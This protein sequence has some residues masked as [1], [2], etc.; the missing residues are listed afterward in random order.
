MLRES[1]QVKN[2]AAVDK[3]LL[4]GLLA[5]PWL[6][7]N[8]GGVVEDMSSQME[9][10][11]GFGM[12]ELKG[13]PFASLFPNC[14]R[15]GELPEAQSILAVAQGE[16]VSSARLR[17]KTGRL[18]NAALFY[19]KLGQS[20][21]SD[22]KDSFNAPLLIVV[23]EM[24]EEVPSG[25]LL[26]NVQ[27]KLEGYAL[28]QEKWLLGLGQQL[29]APLTVMT[30]SLN[31]LRDYGNKMSAQERTEEIRQ[32]EECVENCR[33][34]IEAAHSRIRIKSRPFPKVEVVG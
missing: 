20:K 30:L 18:I 27:K 15:E 19:K 11:L 8:P 32:L 21:A 17:H 28:E 14:D 2:S 9:T 25:E 6:R 1:V 13:V 10:L 12:N 5:L 3:E 4:S 7:L 24:L 16:T 26:L 34:I 29:R 31:L 22:G 33:N 23:M